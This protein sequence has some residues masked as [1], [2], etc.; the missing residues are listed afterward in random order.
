M[1]REEEEAMARFRNGCTEELHRLVR[2]VER[3]EECLKVTH[4]TSRHGRAA[5]QNGKSS[6]VIHVPE[7][8]MKAIGANGKRNFK[9]T[10]L[11]AV[12]NAAYIRSFELMAER[13]ELMRRIRQVESMLEMGTTK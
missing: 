10:D 5:G 3:V 8:V 4:S 12:R 11:A 6:G 2:K 9:T 1:T 13:Q 7:D